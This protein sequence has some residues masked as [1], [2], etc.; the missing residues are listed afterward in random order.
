MFNNLQIFKQAPKMIKRRK[1]LLKHK[2]KWQ[3]C[4]LK[5]LN[6]WLL[7]GQLEGPHKHLVLHRLL[8]LSQ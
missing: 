7:K 6:N 1:L 2:H 3:V 5:S 4:L 8:H